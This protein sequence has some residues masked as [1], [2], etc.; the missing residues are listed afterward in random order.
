MNKHDNFERVNKSPYYIK[1]GT[2]LEGPYKVRIYNRVKDCT[3]ELERCY[4][5][6]CYK[7]RGLD[8]G[9]YCLI[10]SAI[11]T[12]DL[13]K[14]KEYLVVRMMD[15]LPLSRDRKRIHH[16]TYTYHNWPYNRDKL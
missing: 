12:L 5:Q 11:P 6:T 14:G 9:L 2:E 7:F 13:G 4:I 3:F 1:K 8:K 16:S 15:V 10:K